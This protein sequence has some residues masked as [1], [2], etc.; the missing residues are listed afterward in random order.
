MRERDRVWAGKGQRERHTQ[1]PKQAPGSELS[2]RCPTQARTHE[3]WD[4]HLSRSQTLNWLSHPGAPCILSLTN[5]L[6]LEFTDFLLGLLPGLQEPV[7]G[8]ETNEDLWGPG[9]PSEK[10]LPSSWVNGEPN[11]PHQC[12]S[13]KWQWPSGFSMELTFEGWGGSWMMRRPCMVIQ[14]GVMVAGKNTWVK[15]VK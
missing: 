13:S 10:V 5:K 12:P 14:V 11:W 8:R 9:T 2:A 7:W 15:Q 1:N 4:H 6:I 3:P